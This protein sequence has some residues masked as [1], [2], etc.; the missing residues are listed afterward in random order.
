M[1]LTVAPTCQSIGR[2][3]HCH[4]RI[5]PAIPMR[6]MAERSAV[7]RGRGRDGACPGK[8]G[9]G[10]PDSGRG[11][12]VTGQAAWARSAAAAGYNAFIQANET[13]GAAGT[14]S[15]PSVWVTSSV[16]PLF[17]SPN[18]QAMGDSPDREIGTPPGEQAARR[19]AEL[20]GRRRR[21]ENDPASTVREAAIARR[22]AEEAHERARHA[23]LLAAK[24]FEDSA[25]VHERVAQVLEQAA[26]E[27]GTPDASK[28]RRAAARHHQA[29]A[30]DRQMARLKR[31]QA[32]AE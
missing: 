9:S 1:K 12:R 18:G 4:L 27:S 17:N 13:F 25:G 5:D 31:E 10:L 22:K 2:F 15:D 8:P 21:L 30:E 16:Y 23:A 3:S 26:A 7:G 11:N 28:H 14:Y 24:S 6:G 19:T 20:Q 29:A 32:D